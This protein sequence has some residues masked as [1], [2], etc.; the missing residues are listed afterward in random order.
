M[1]LDRKS[2]ISELMWTNNEKTPKSQ[3]D[4][5]LRWLYMYVVV[6]VVVVNTY[7]WIQEKHHKQWKSIKWQSLEP[8]KSSSS[9]KDSAERALICYVATD[10]EELTASKSELGKQ[11]A[12][13]V[14]KG[15]GTLFK[16]FYAES[17]CTVTVTHTLIH[18][19]CKSRFWCLVCLNQNINLDL[20]SV[21]ESLLSFYLRRHCIH[22]CFTLGTPQNSILKTV[23]PWFLGLS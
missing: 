10:A 2:L 12:V 15:W 8:F 4:R 22:S 17:S 19:F 23:L 20:F 9:S 21:A 16:Q 14:C 7:V 11:H 3:L 6:V 1:S 5:N 13:F 18:M